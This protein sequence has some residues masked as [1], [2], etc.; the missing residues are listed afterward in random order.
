MVYAVNLYPKFTPFVYK[1]MDD[2]YSLDH[3][4]SRIYIEN[5]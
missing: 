2:H 4:I 5:I 1:V 3:H